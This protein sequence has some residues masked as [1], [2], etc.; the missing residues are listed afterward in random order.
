MRKEQVSL[1]LIDRFS[2]L[3]KLNFCKRATSGK[4]V[5]LFLRLDSTEGRMS[6]FCGDFV[7][8]C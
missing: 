4:L 5:D 7:L 8:L 3:K 6:S 1:R 2:S